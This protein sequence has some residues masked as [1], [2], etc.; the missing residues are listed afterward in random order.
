[1]KDF[2]NEIDFEDF[3]QKVRNGEEPVKPGEKFIMPGNQVV[4]CDG[5]KHPENYNYK[6]ETHTVI[7]P[8]SA[9]IIKEDK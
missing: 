3:L 4:T 7:I 6:E 1:M 9:I 8:R 5:Y 2:S